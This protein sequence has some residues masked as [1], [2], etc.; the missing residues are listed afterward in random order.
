[1][2]SERGRIE[3]WL[4]VDM[5][6]SGTNVQLNARN[7]GKS[8]NSVQRFSPKNQQYQNSFVCGECKV[9]WPNLKVFHPALRWQLSKKN[10]IPATF[11]PFKKLAFCRFS[12]PVHWMNEDGHLYHVF[13]DFCGVWTDSVRLTLLTANNLIQ[14]KPARKY[15]GK[16]LVLGRVQTFHK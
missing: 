1:M 6:L 14:P 4:T 13:Y 8:R 15:Y 10:A 12:L 2:G 11:W 7:S 5:K 9:R 16:S 3:T